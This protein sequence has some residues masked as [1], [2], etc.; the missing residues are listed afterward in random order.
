MEKEISIDALKEVVNIGTGQAATSLSE[1]LNQK[2]MINVPE[3][4]FVPL[5]QISEQLGGNERIII[6]VYFQTTGE[7][8]SRILLLFSRETGH[9]LASLLTGNKTN[10][11]APLGELEQSSIMELGNII[12]NSYINAM[13]QLLNIKLYPSVPFYAEDMLGAVID[14]LL[15]EIS[16]VAD[17]S[18]LLKTKMMAESVDLNGSFVIFPDDVFLKKLFGKLGIDNSISMKK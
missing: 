4:K 5:D 2:I 12:A 17:Y 14:F 3:A 16:Q 8:E 7:L 6:G 1:I 15:A 9:K 18:L 10:G 11:K 13:S